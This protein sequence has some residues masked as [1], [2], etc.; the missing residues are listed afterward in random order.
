MISKEQ[1]LK[2]AGLSRLRVHEKE[3]EKLKKDVDS[4]LNYVE[5]INEAGAK[6]GAAGDKGEKS[7]EKDSA[8]AISEI[9]IVRNV[10]RE[11]KNP[12]QSGLYTEVLVSAALARQGNY[13]KVKKIL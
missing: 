11:D 6:L 13:V 2:L 10:L 8:G 1:I 9:H 5:K 7:D 4:I 12:H 3:V